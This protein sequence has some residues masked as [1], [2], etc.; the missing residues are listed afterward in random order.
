MLW[1]MAV[2][3]VLCV[4]GMLACRGDISQAQAVAQAQAQA[5]AQAYLQVSLQGKAQ[6]KQQEITALEAAFSPNADR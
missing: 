1:V 4:L 5:L 3:Q 2:T 6:D